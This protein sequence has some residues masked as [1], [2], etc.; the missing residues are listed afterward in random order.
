MFKPAFKHEYF[1]T[2]YLFLESFTKYFTT[3]K[4]AN[5]KFKE[6]KQIQLFYRIK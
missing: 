3:R 6:R 1:C 2:S 4:R 5:I